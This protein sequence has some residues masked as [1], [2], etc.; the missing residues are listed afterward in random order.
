M[1]VFCSTIKG[2]NT[3]IDIAPQLHPYDA[4]GDA[5]RAF[6]LLR[7]LL[8]LVYATFYAIHLKN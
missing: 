2:K 8:V 3:K 6:I 1:V 7:L 4:V 5:E